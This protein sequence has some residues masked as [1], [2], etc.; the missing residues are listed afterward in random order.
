MTEREFNKERDRLIH[1]MSYGTFLERMTAYDEFVKFMET[2]SQN[3]HWN[4][5]YNA[6]YVGEKTA[7]QLKKLFNWN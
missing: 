4:P 6:I 2:K 1:K 7:K 3:S 5:R